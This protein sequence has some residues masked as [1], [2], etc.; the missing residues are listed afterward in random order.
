MSGTN[1][2]TAVLCAG[3]LYVFSLSYLVAPL[4]GWHLE[5]ATLA[6]GFAAW[7]IVAKVATKFVVAMPFTYHVVN[8]FRHF[9]W[10]LG[11][12]FANKSVIRSGWAA[13]V[14]SVGSAVVL[15]TMY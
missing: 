8:S 6:A 1:R 2:A 10:D 3:G 5:S 14:V 15:A 4:F 12:E 7:P 9:A 11:K 13:V